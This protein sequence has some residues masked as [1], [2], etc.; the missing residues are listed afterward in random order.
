MT[1]T[2]ERYRAWDEWPPWVA[3]WIIAVPLILALLVFNM[4]CDGKITRALVAL[5]S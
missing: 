2:E 3:V 1:T 5:L 4:M